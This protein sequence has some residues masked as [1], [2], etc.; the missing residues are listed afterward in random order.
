MKVLIIGT[1]AI[2]SYFGFKLAQS[3]AEVSMMARS[4]YQQIRNHGI[5]IQS[6]DSDFHFQPKQVVRNAAELEQKPDYLMLCIKVVAGVDRVSLLKDAVGPDTAIVLLCNG[7][8]IEEE[9]AAAFPDN[10]IISGLA[11]IGVTR[12]SPGRVHHQSFGNL[13]FGS[14]PSGISAKT[15]SLSDAYQQ[16]GVH[17]LASD[18]IISARWQKCVWN[19]A[20]NPVSVLSGLDT[21][22]ILDCQENLIRKLM[23]EVCSIA[24]AVGHPLPET[25]VDKSIHS[26]HKMLGYKTSML[27]DYET[28]RPMETE[29][30]LGNTVRAGQKAGVAIPCLE[31]VYALMKLK[32][33]RA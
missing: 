28:G 23:R 20:F 13:S 16:V 5:L 8:G 25:L 32:E 30:I 12:T 7:I 14:Y 33:I 29:A 19:A 18:N 31:T 27:V 9:I 1:G 17:C 2:G 15:Q 24:A 11:F 6:K 3:G 26:T 4:D 21:K 10:E 22:Q